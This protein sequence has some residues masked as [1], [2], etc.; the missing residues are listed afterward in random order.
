[1]AFTWDTT[2]VGGTGTYDITATAGPV[3]GETDTADNIGNSLTDVFVLA[4]SIVVV[5]S[6]IMDV[7]LTVDET[8]TVSIYT[9]YNST[10][11]GRTDVWGY[12]LTLSWNASILEGL[13]VTNGGNME[14]TDTWV[15]DNVTKTFFTTKKP[16]IS[17]SEKVYVN[18]TL[19]TKP[20]DY[21]IDYTTG[22]ITFTTA[23]D[24]VSIQ[25][26]YMYDATFMSIA[27]FTAGKFDNVNGRLSL[28]SN[29]V[30]TTLSGPGALASV[31]F[32]VAGIGDCDI[33]L[34]PE[35]RLIRSDGSR[36]T[37][38][39]RLKHGFFTNGID[40]KTDYVGFYVK[41][42][43]VVSYKTQAYPTWT[44]PIT[45][46]VTARNTRLMETGPFN[47]AVYYGANLIENRVITKGLGP[48]DM[49][50]EKFNWTLSGVAWGLYNI[51]A[52]VISPKDVNPANDELIDGTVK[53]K[54]PGDIDGDWDVDPF[55]FSAFRLAYGSKGPPQVPSPQPNYNP[56][57]DF[58]LDGDVDPFDFSTFRLN[59]GKTA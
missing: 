17:G 30:S 53:I 51:T 48:G 3:A 12:E 45:I 49:R 57:A 2:Y 46:E 15:G 16:I 29:N 13:S 52:K 50:T 26:K 37:L 56:E 7:T 4:P 42:D 38:P 8:V 9:D 6:S 11:I 55:D 25:A 54:I 23:P 59:Y 32:N 21:K 22:N 27:N 39:H 5:P 41:I 28:T 14:A 1:L 10:L 58:D 19:K 24:L 44:V 34:G 43:N 31:T 20:A 40:V 35:T 18:A 47:L 36:I 33:I